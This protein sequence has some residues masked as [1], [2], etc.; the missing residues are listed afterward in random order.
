MRQ[1]FQHGL[2]IFSSVSSLSIAV[3]HVCS[4]WTDIL[5]IPTISMS[6]KR[7]EQ[8]M[9]HCWCFHCSHKIQPLDV[10]VFKS[11]KANYDQA[12]DAWLRNHP[13]RAVTEYNVAELLVEAWGKAVTRAGQHDI[14]ATSS[15]HSYSKDYSKQSISSCCGSR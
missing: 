3:H 15:S 7:Q 13:G 2:T 12:V 14:D 11:L 1:Y 4:S 8:I 9:Y 5:R 6:S 10:A